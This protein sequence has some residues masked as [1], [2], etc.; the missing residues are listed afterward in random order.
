MG[1]RKCYLIPVNPCTALSVLKHRE[2]RKRTINNRRNSEYMRTMCKWK[3]FSR[4]L[5]SLMTYSWLCPLSSSLFPIVLVT[6]KP[7]SKS[8]FLFMSQYSWF[9]SKLALSNQ[10]SKS[11]H[12]YAFLKWRTIA[13]NTPSIL[14][15]S[16][17]ALRLGPYKEDTKAFMN[18]RMN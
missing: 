1:N 10:K 3:Q 4:M 5:H 7:Q 15:S 6:N 18:T 9:Y 14:T 11:A 12:T 16:V 2:K 17:A 13:S 8:I